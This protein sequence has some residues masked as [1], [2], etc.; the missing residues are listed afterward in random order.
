MNRPAGIGIM[1]LALLLAAISPAGLKAQDA[2]GADSREIKK[3][4]RKLL[5]SGTSQFDA[6]LFDSA[7]TKF[8]SVLGLDPANPDA[9]YFLARITIALGDTVATVASLKEAVVKAPRSFRLKRF[10]ARLYLALNEPSEA[11]KLA[12]EVLLIRRR[13]S[14]ALYLKGCALLMTGDS[15]Q[16]IEHLGKALEIIEARGKK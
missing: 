3:Q 6:G 16:A 7:R 11:Q 10:L 2:A 5:K 12:E 8:D 14:E 1:F 15:A 4:V 9:P 13:D